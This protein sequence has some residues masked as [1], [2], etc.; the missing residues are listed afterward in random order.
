[1]T[2][3]LDIRGSGRAFFVL[4]QG[5]T[6]GGPYSSHDNAISA[7]GGIERRLKPD[8]AKFRSCS[9]CRRGFLSTGDTHCPSCREGGR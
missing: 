6:V 7:L 2:L 1:M 5:V 4:H 8:T 9:G 3:S